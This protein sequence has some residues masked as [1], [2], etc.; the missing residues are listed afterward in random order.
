[1]AV[2]NHMR[3]LPNVLELAARTSSDPKWIG[4]I[5]LA[6]V[7]G[8]DAGLDKGQ[9]SILAMCL[10]ELDQRAAARAAERERK[11]RQR[12]RNGGVR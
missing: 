9:R 12:A 8:S 6:L 11:R 5:V 2:W 7:D 3:L 10:M 1:M 4:E